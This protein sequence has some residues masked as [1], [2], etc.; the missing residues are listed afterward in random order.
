VTGGYN[1]HIGH[2]AGYGIT[3]QSHSS[4]TFVGYNSGYKITTG[5]NNVLMGRN[6]AYYIST[7]GNNVCLGYQAGE[8]ITSGTGNV[9][10]GYMAGETNLTTGNNQLWIAN[11][12]TATPPIYGELDN[13]N[14]GLSQTSFGDNATKTLAISTGVAPTTNPVD[15]FQ[16]YSADIAAGEAAPH[17][18]TEHGDV[19][20]LYQQAHVA[21]ADGTLADIT[22][23]F[24]T[25]LGNLEN[26]GLL[27]AA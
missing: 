16:L 12:N 20:K 2:G 27:A 15:C 7:G 25:V 14:I 6:S 8:D 19:I 11:T 13:G 18:E 1:V 23:K 26:T 5:A 4:N 21:D 9:C 3:G 10:I 24:N 22:T 17:F